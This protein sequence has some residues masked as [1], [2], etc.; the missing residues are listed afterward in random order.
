MVQLLS[1]TRDAFYQ[2]LRAHKTPND[3]LISSDDFVDWLGGLEERPW[4]EYRQGRPI[5]KTQLARALAPFH[6]SPSTVRI[7]AATAKGYKLSAFEKSVFALSPPIPLF[8][9]VAPSQPPE[10]LVVSGFS[11]TSQGE[12]CGV[13]KSG[14]T[15]QFSAGCDGVTALPKT[16]GQVAEMIRENHRQHPDWSTTQISKATGQPEK[17]VRRA[18]AAGSTVQ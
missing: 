13:S 17:R 18:L 2:C 14:V 1:D 3:V 10:T 8:R 15:S 4:P 11:E 9:N 6:V 16:P 7:G 12:L 5:T